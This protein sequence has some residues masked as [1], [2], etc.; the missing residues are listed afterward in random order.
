MYYRNKSKRVGEA[1]GYF[2]SYDDCKNEWRNI[3][4]PIL[5]Q[6]SVKD[7]K[8]DIKILDFIIDNDLE[9]ECEIDFEEINNGRTAEQ[10]QARWKILLKNFGSS[11]MPKKVNAKAE[12]IKQGLK[13]KKRQKPK[14]PAAKK[15]QR[16]FDIFEFYSQNY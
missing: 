7:K 13:T 15:V 9:S 8:A 11:H 4:Y 5:S 6:T 2:R 16:K 3:I 1:T 12:K 10:N 14:R